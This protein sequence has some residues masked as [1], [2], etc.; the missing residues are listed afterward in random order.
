L[1]KN[2]PI[3]LTSSIRFEAKHKVSKAIASAIFCRIN[4]GHTSS[5]KLQF[6][7]VMRFLTNASLGESVLK[8]LVIILE[9]L[10]LYLVRVR[11]QICV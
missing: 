8:Q 5:Y 3:L 9:N 11:F 7:M 6:Q 10:T 1:R 4:L 2:D